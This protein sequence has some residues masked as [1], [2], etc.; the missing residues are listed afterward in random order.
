MER[1]DLQRERHA[2]RQWWRN[3]EAWDRRTTEIVV[4]VLRDGRWFVSRCSFAA[5]EQPGCAYGGRHG[6]HYARA[7]AGRWMRTIGGIWVQAWRQS[8]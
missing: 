1:I 5:A 4:G 7:T 2:V 8:G 3:G 6:E